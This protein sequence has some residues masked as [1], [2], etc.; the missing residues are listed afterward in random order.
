[1]TNIVYSKLNNHYHYSTIKFKLIIYFKLFDLK[2]GCT[3]LNDKYLRL[4]FYFNK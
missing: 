1:M 3:Y 4:Y 2:Q